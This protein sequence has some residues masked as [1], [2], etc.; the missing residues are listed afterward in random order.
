MLK[1]GGTVAKPIASKPGRSGFRQ[2]CLAGLIA[3]VL[4][5][6][7]MAPA[8]AALPKPDQVVQITGAE[9][10]GNLATAPTLH[11]NATILPGWHINSDK[12]TSPDYIAT[13]LSIVAPQSLAVKDV[14]YPPAQM[15]APEFSMGEKLSVFTGAVTFDAPL[16]QKTKPS[17]GQALAFNLSLDYQ[18]CNDRQCLRPVT[19]TKQVALQWPGRRQ[20]CAAASENLWGRAGQ[21]S[22]RRRRPVYQLRLRARLRAGLPRRPRAQSDALRLSADRR[23]ASPT[24]AIRVAAEPGAS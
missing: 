6:A 10:G 15:I 11:V 17:P 12:P 19:I 22:G 20:V 18:A 2:K 23:H 21:R 8:W 13:K 14:R 24:S 5:L 4:A 3:A 1:L 7:W 9:F 16:E